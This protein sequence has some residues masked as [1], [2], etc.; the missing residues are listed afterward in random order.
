[1]LDEDRSPPLLGE[2]VP[3]PLSSLPDEQDNV[4]VIASPRAAT[5]ANFVSLLFIVLSPI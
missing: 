2:D 3:P 5:F 4:N 1:M